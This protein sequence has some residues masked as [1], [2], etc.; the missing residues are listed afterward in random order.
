MITLV[1]VVVVAYY[2]GCSGYDI[3]NYGDDSNNFDNNINNN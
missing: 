1:I 2:D 3:N